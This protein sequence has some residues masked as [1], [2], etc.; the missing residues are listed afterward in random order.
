MD[1]LSSSCYVGGFLMSLPPIESLKP[2]A[3]LELHKI[4]REPEDFT[5]TE[6]SHFC[7]MEFGGFGVA[8]KIINDDPTNTLTYRLH[9]NR[10]RARIVPVNSEIEIN[11]W[12]DII[13]VTPNAVTGTG[14][15]EIDVV[16]FK[17]A[18]RVKQ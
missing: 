9:S 18:K 16:P 6:V 15:L 7:S 5:T 10:G 12:F 8:A 13:I 11:E 1:L 3:S 17:D 14:Q 4:A 2:V